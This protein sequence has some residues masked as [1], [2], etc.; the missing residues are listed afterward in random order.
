MLSTP[1]KNKGMKDK[2]I[3]VGNINKKNMKVV[4][5][6]FL[7]R[8]PEKHKNKVISTK[9]M[10][11]KIQIKLIGAFLIPVGFI[12]LLGVISFL[13][14]SD[15]LIS[16][17]KTATLS[18]MNNMSS[19]IDLGLE[20]VTDKSSLLNTNTT[21]QN[22]YS[23]K[24][25]DDIVTEQ[26]KFKELQE[27]VFADILSNN[28]IKSIYIF[29]NYGKGIMTQGVPD[30]TLYNDFMGSE[31]G[32]A[33]LDSTEK[34]Q[35]MGRHPFLDQ[36]AGI[37]NGDYSVSYIS[38]I[39]NSNSEKVGFIVL[40]VSMD[41]VQKALTNSGLPKE[42][43]VAFVSQD[44][45]EIRSDSE[46]DK[47]YF[48]GKD[49]YKK[50]ID[51]DT[52]ANGYEN[53][54][55]NHENYLFLYSYITQSNSYLCA[56]IPKNIITRQAGDV[57]NFTIVI[58][59]IASITAILFGTMISSGISNTI[60]NINDVLKKSASG[61]LTHKIH[62]RR[63]DEFLLLGNGINQLIDS[64]KELIRD[65]AKVGNTVL[66]S[67]S[68]VSENSNILFHT[69]Q[70]ISSA[71]DEVKHGI[72]SQSQGTESCLLQMS[73]L[74]EQ[75]GRVSDNAYSI[76]KSAEHTKEV[77]SKGITIVDNLGLKTK[78]SAEIVKTVIINIE[79]LEQKSQ[80]I[81]D[82][83]RGINEISEQ[84]NLLSLNASIEAARAGKEGKGFQVVANEIRKLA[85]RSSKESERIGKIVNQ[86]QEQT[87]LTVVT[88]R[89]AEDE[90]VLREK[91][92]NSA[93]EIFSDI[94]QNVENLTATLNHIVEGIKEIE[95]AKED[96]LGLV[97]EISAISEQTTTAMDQLTVTAMEQLK[98]V[99]A[100]NHAVEELGHDSDTLEVKVNIFKTEE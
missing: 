61:D 27:Y 68:G 30:S 53:V 56:L 78:E 19:Y 17:Y 10:T 47:E 37:E 16:N 64:I 59:L 50:I 20:M 13:K 69:T 93:I 91:A 7:N 18:N 8:K 28:I 4:K 35:W 92:L 94:D 89:Q 32:T 12:I 1:I 29:G 85:E 49:F 96:T 40:D 72:N 62:M 14:S 80:A 86:I 22:Y 90:E 2:A 11:G 76:R 26:K 60:K 5:D 98:A 100:L 75:I 74:S 9:G 65:M 48:I 71:V 77:V 36:K 21:L 97:E 45:K 82:I 39:Y 66:T 33:F 25:S 38:Y 63:K 42:S 44:G 41:F 51:K 73:D 99:E 31:E 87:R 81:S 58:V 43:K 15:A 55:V 46:T 95:K 34:K 54:S 57:R 24:Y 88:A 67:A 23:G 70:N 83:V 52:K 6:I 3:K 84:T 79:N